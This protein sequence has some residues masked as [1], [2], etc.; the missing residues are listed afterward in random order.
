MKINEI[1]KN[2]RHIIEVDLEKNNLET[3]VNDLIKDDK[4]AEKIARNGYR[5][6]KKYI[7][8]KMIAY[9]WLYY[10][11]NVNNLSCY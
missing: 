4:K 9:Y 5:F 2:N 10:M 8:K 3:I 7:N 1:L 6:F 11:N